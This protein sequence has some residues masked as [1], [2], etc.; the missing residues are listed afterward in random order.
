MALVTRH[1]LNTTVDTKKPVFNNV[2]AFLKQFNGILS[3]QAGKYTLMVETKTD[4]ISSSVSG[5][6][7]QNARYITNEDI[8]G[9]VNIKDAGPKKS[10][11]SLEATIADP[12][13]KWNDR[14]ISFYDS[15]YLK[16]DRGI[17]K[18]GRI[19]VSAVTNYHNARISIENYLRKIITVEIRDVI[20][21]KK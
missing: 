2:N 18:E 5:G 17:K 3:Y 13:I 19:V 9:S 6:Y 8:L 21:I 7:E 15:D 16:Q 4:P 12:A 1:Q 14:Q 20:V 10:Y 11:N